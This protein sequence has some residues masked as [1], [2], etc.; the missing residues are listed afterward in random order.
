[1]P[2]II[3][4]LI[5]SFGTL[6]VLGTLSAFVSRMFVTRA[7]RRLIQSIGKEPLPHFS[8][9][10][11]RTLPDPVRR[12]LHY[13]L[14]EGQPNIRYAVLKQKARFRHRPGSPWFTVKATEVI[15]GMEAGFVWDAVLRHNRAW[16]RTAKLSYMKGEGHGHIKLFGSLTLQE[17]EGPETDTSMLFRFLS[18]LVWLPTGLLPTKT[19]RWEPID[20]STARAVITDGDTQVQATFHVNEIGEI[21][22]IVTGDKYRDHKSGFEQATFTLRCRNYSEFEG[23]MIPTEVDFAWNLESGDFEY[24]QFN[25]IDVA[26]HC[27]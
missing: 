3:V 27:E 20:E 9:S 6:V 4:I 25:I 5:A 1:M 26:Y 15:S 21:D 22:R 10:L 11:A 2:K 23:V 16:W 18:E 12:Y 13:A 19:L 8:A 17:Y 24:G 14:K 7:I